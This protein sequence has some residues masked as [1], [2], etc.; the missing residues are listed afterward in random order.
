MAIGE[1][2]AAYPD[3][4]EYGQTFVELMSR[5]VKRGEC[6]GAD[7]LAL[8]RRACERA[9]ALLGRFFASECVI[10]AV[11]EFRELFATWLHRQGRADEARLQR[12]RTEAMIELLAGSA[13]LPVPERKYHDFKGG[14]FAYRLLDSPGGL[15]EIPVSLVVLLHAKGACGRDNTRPLCMPLLRALVGYVRR[16]AGR[17][18]F[19]VPQ[20]PD[21]RAATWFGSSR[22]T[23]DALLEGLSDLIASTASRLKVSSERVFLVGE[24]EGADAAL[25]LA[26]RSP[27]LAGRVLAAGP[28]AVPPEDAARIQAAVHVCQSEF[29]W[30][31][32]RDEMTR[33]LDALGGTKRP[34]VSVLQ[35][36]YRTT[37]GRAAAAEVYLDWLFGNETVNR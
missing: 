18:V 37:V 32:H 11:T 35:G 26:A 33:G 7:D 23:P 19:L 16:Q 29:D 28:R 4:L 9:D 15:P 5:L 27:G 30:A 1:L 36:Q 31:I 17:T 10:V 22:K 12:V 3:K 14:E 20:C 13:S 2:A 25:A 24:Q 6:K 8:L 21:G 34:V